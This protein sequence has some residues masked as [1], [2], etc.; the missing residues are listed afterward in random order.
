MDY[1]PRTNSHINIDKEVVIT[2]YVNGKEKVL[3]TGSIDDPEAEHSPAF[4]VNLSGR[5]YGKKLLDTRLTLTSI[6]TLADS[7][8]RNDLIKYI[9][10]QAGLTEMEIPEMEAVTIDNSFS[11]Q[12]A[13]DMIQKEAMV[14]LYWVKFDEE[15]KM[16]LLLDDIKSDTSLYPTP[17]WTYSE[18]RIIRLNYRKSRVEI[19]KIIVLGQTIQRRIPVTTTYIPNA[20][21]TSTGGTVT[22]E[23]YSRTL[24]SDSLS[25]AEE[26][27]IH[28]V[29]SSNYYKMMGDFFIRL[30]SG[31]WAPQPQLVIAIG[32]KLSNIWESY[33]ITSVSAAFNGAGISDVIYKKDSTALGLWGLVWTLKRGGSGGYSGSAFTFDVT[34]EGYK[35]QTLSDIET[36]ED[37]YDEINEPDTTYET[38]YD[39]ISVSV[40][41]P[42]S[43][44]KYGER[45]GGS[46]EFPLLETQAQC[47]AVGR[48][49]IR[50]SHRLLGQIEFNIPFNPLM[51]T[52]QT[53]AIT[54]TKIGI[55]ERYY[56]ES[57]NHNIDFADGNINARTTV[58]GVLYV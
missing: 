57:V 46:I 43:I 10:E 47:E 22:F 27:V 12:S 24:F 14:E 51:Q 40:S 33:I 31:K 25:Y 58:G 15:G 17:D 48:K 55:D 50:D 9:A 30:Q 11:D 7:T 8:K 4:R 18:S 45:D 5:D 53:V 6:Q 1:S 23:P 44:A 36:I 56:I 3:F 2:A 41:D 29:Y 26:E 37:T 35:K 13:W 49:I 39:Q 38:R 21:Y 16:Q 20:D 42:N 19:N 28:Y 54:D 32:C 52:G 34:I